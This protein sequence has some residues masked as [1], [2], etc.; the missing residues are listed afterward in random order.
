MPLLLLPP[1][2]GKGPG[3]RGGWDPAVGQHRP[4]AEGRAEVAAALASAMAEPALV[5][6]LTGLRGERAQAAAHANRSAVGAPVLPAWQRYRGVVWEHLDPGGL[7]RAGRRRAGRILVVSGLGGLFGFDEPVPDYKLKMGASL[8]GPGPLARYW[9]P[10]LTAALAAEAA[11]GEVWDLLP[12]EHRR[13][14]DLPAA[15]IKAVTVNFLAA[16]GSGAAGHGAKAAKGRFARH[17]LE[18]AGD[19]LEAADGFSWAGWTARVED[20]GLVTVTAPTA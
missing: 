14:L 11:G 5:A 9:K 10:R 16:G 3:G 13:A 6:R 8:P 20:A 17:L 4:I 19:F 12:G 18:S 15:G 7:S 2:E 1:S